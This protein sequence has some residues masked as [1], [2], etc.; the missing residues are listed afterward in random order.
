LQIYFTP[1]EVSD[2]YVVAMPGIHILNEMVVGEEL[3]VRKAQLLERWVPDSATF[4]FS[5][6]STPN[7]GA[8]TASYKLNTWGSFPGA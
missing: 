8:H 1:K 4:F 3:D 6:V 5:T 7:L 2:I